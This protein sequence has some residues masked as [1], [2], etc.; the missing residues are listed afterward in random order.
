MLSD[1]HVLAWYLGIDWFAL[2]MLTS[3][4]CM[5]C[6]IISTNLADVTYSLSNNII[7]NILSHINCVYFDHM[8]THKDHHVET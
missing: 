5:Y 1:K 8:Q 3:L 4:H 7:S 6:K 2:Y